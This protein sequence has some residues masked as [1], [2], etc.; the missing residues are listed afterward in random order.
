MIIDMFVTNEHSHMLASSGMLIT[1]IGN[2][3]DNPL[4]FGIIT[5]QL[6]K[7]AWFL[8]HISALCLFCQYG[9]K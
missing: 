8:L 5:H 3:G 7:K 1:A 9:Y 4:E 2:K 6:S